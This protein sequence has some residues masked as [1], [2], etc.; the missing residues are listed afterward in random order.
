MPRWLLIASTVFVLLSLL[1]PPWLVVEPVT[2]PGILQGVVS[3][4]L[5]T[6]R[7]LAPAPVP[8]IVDW[9]QAAIAPSARDLLSFSF[10]GAWVRW[11]ITLALIVTGL[12]F[13][14]AI[15]SLFVA[16]DFV[17]LLAGWTGAGGGGLLLLLL[18]LCAPSLQRLGLGVGSLGG[19]LASVLGVHLAW[20]FWVT[21]LGLALM[22]GAGFAVLRSPGN[23]RR[24]SR[25]Y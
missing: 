16:S 1:I 18:L 4:L 6:A 2:L 19:L 15:A 22:T 8:Q 25:R 3:T 7:T 13:L 5:N 17:R 20:G 24:P 12:G 9:L 11:L 10:V 14:L 21:T 23:T